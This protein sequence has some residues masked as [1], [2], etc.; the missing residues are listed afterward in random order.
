MSFSGKSGDDED[1]EPELRRVS[2]FDSQNDEEELVWSRHL[3]EDEHKDDMPSFDEKDQER[4]PA[5][6][7]GHEGKLG[8]VFYRVK[9]YLLF[10]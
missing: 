2:A 8:T 7:I 6:K 10:A 1:R 3:D 9:S 4:V 5:V